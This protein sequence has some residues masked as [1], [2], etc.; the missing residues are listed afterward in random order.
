M[1]HVNN[2][3]AQILKNVS[4]TL[5]MDQNL[6]VL[7]ANGSGKTTLAKL[8][9]NLIDN[10]NVTFKGKILNQFSPKKRAQTINYVP[11]KLTVY[12]EYLTVLDYLRL[13]V[14]EENDF[15]DFDAVLHLLNIAH[16]KH[17]RCVNLS[18]GESSLLMIG[19]AMIHNALFTVLDE[20]TANLDQEK[21]VKLYQI[22]KNSSAFR[23]KIIITHDLNLAYQLGY[24][25]LY[26][27]KGSVRFFGECKAFFEPDHIKSCF[28][29]YVKNIDG[30]YLV[31]YNETI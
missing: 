20:P 3:S 15:P 17:S 26:L 7:G 22:L 25:I 10:Q 13:N 28:G 31:N 27:D 30:N 23:T 19:G 9:C 2:L 1:L 8:L 21:K 6:T 5:P 11:A 14:I 29:N 18:S 24:T 4:F 16:L 12:D